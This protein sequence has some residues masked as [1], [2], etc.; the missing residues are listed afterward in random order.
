MDE[1]REHSIRQSQ[2]LVRNRHFWGIVV[3]MAAL[4][5]FY[6]AN[7]IDLANWFPWLKEVFTTEFIHDLH[8][9]LFL[10]PLL[11]AGAMF[12]VRGAIACW[13]VFLAAVMPRALYFSPYPDSLPRTVTFSLMALLAG[14]LIALEENQRQRERE[15]RAKLEIANHTYVTKVL[16]A[17][18]SERQRIAQELHDSVQQDLVVIANRSQALTAGEPGGLPSEVRLQAKDISDIAL[19]AADDVR[20]ISHDLRP[21]ILDRMGLMASLRWLT[22]HL[23]EGSG[24]TI[25][26][27]VN[28]VERRLSPEAELVFFRI[29]QE[30]LNNT[31]RHSQA[32]KATITVDFAAE[33]LRIVVWDNGKGFLPPKEM[34]DFA[35]H[36]KLGLNGIQ[37]RAKL[38]GA[39]LGIQSESGK[40]TTITVEAK[41]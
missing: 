6:N 18:E 25:D 9:S 37:Q 21:S 15:A 3:I 5:V 10:I 12:R 31:V 11:Y 1:V 34:R 33:S 13:L 40:G 30:A 38:L 23:A 29:V 28:G 32:T 20:R 16:Q 7:Y 39:T 35:I 17:Q 22:K 26:I 4:I 41:V 14:M 19:Q 8:R 2:K 24:I 36:G 27:M